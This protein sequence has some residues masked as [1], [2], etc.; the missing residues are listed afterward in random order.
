MLLFVIEPKYE[1][2]QDLAISGKDKPAG[3]WDEA[4]AAAA[5][6]M[7]SSRKLRPA[8]SPV[9]A[10]RVTGDGIGGGVSDGGGV[11]VT[12]LTAARALWL[13]LPPQTDRQ[14]GAA[15]V[16]PVKRRNRRHIGWWLMGVG[17]DQWQGER[18]SRETRAG[19]EK[20][21]TAG[22]R[23]GGQRERTEVRAELSLSG[24]QLATREK[25]RWVTSVIWQFHPSNG[26]N[27]Q[28]SQSEWTHTCLN[29]LNKS[30]ALSQFTA[31]P[32]LRLVKRGM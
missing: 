2:W 3:G 19:E 7:T 11:M 21:K 18:K 1:W 13:T 28:F 9:D 29:L 12:W 15:D 4:A 20:I 31:W 22:S 26:H 32:Y 30:K 24:L 17:T 27:K 23:G 6:A 8:S 5:A 25:E 14:E 10:G 16:S